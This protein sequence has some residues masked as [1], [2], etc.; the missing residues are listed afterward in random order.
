MKRRIFAI[1]EEIEEKQN[2]EQEK[3]LNP[4]T[5]NQNLENITSDNNIEEIQNNI[6]DVDDINI[7]EEIEKER[8]KK[9]QKLK[10]KEKLNQIIK[11]LKIEKEKKSKDDIKELKD[12]LSSHYDFFRNLLKQSEERFLKLIPVLNFE[13]FEANERIVNFGEEG[14]K[15]YV[16]LKGSVGIYKPFPITK[17]M[18]LRQYVEYIAKV[19]DEEKN[20]TKFERILNYNSKIDKN[21]LY[22]IDF[23]YTKVP[24]YSTGLTIVLEEERELAIGNSGISFGEMALI[25]NEPRNATIIALEKCFL[26]SID[27]SDYTKIVKDIE[28]QRI[29]RELISFKEKYP[30]FKFWPSSKCF[31]LLSGLIIQELT[32]GDYVYKQNENPT[33]IY[34]IK[35]GIYEVSTYFNFETYERFIEYIHDTTHSLI[36]YIDNPFEW[37][38]DK[39]AKRIEIASKENISPFI[40]NLELEDKVILSHKDEQIKS[41]NQDAAKNLEDELCKNKKKIF[42]SSIQKLYAPDI[43]GFLEGLEL[44]QRLTNVKCISQKGVLMKFPLR[45]FLQLLP[46]DKR[47]NFYLQQRIYEEKKY[48]IAQLKNTAVAKLNFVKIEIDKNLYIKKDFYKVKPRKKNLLEFKKLS[49][50]QS[51]DSLTPAYLNSK[52][53]LFKSNSTID[54]NLIPLGNNISKISSNTNESITSI[55]NRINSGF[56]REEN[57]KRSRNSFITGFKRSILSLT[58]NKIKS[59]QNLYPIEETKIKPSFLSSSNIKEID[60]SENEYV[61]YLENNMQYAITPNRIGNNNLN[62]MTGKK[63]IS[64]EAD[65][66]INEINR[67]QKIFRKITLENYPHHKF[68]LPNIKKFSRINKK[69]KSDFV[70][71]KKVKFNSGNI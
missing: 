35:E 24:M 36:P 70:K 52:Q 5:Q 11:I 71:I 27:K 61:K 3:D 69:N 66:I 33:D 60:N 16:L 51:F 21:Q 18:T 55:D 22:L 46:T 47:N 17:R 9:N 58:K 54:Y 50:F 45:E 57:H 39:I 20:K 59:I 1:K 43:F 38:E 32:R 10:E 67:H 48:I 6:N 68:I 26:I 34:I 64:L 44:K 25:K 7:D 53:K 19:K 42:K 4:L 30:I 65:K 37:K 23:D 8:M 12:Y 13:S 62:L 31:P 49:M 40:I 63:Y 28:E 41:Q 56:Q 29:M 15:C 2:K 14:D